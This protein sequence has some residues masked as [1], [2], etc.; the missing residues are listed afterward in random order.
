MGISCDFE[1]GSMD[2]ETKPTCN[3]GSL[4]LNN[5]QNTYDAV[6]EATT[7][8]T[9]LTIAINSNDANN[10]TNVIDLVSPT[11]PEVRLVFLF[12]FLSHCLLF[13]RF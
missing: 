2:S 6:A 12:L 13:D 11:P 5:G 3:K 9:P 10:S 7:A 1:V 8:K 4:K